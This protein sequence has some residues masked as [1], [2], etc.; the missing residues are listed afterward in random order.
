MVTVMRLPSLNPLKKAADWPPT[1]TVAPDR[2][3]PITSRRPPPDALPEVALI[4]LIVGAA[5]AVLETVTPTLAAVA[6]LPAASRARAERVCA[7]LLAV[8]VLQL[9]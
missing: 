4:R 9:I 6:V 8:V 1:V 7:P 2:L 5:E 3:V